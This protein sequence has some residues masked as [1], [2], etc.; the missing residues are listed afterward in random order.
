[1]VP[2]FT[3]ASAVSLVVA[4]LGP[5]DLSAAAR[6]SDRPP[7]CA[8]LSG[9]SGASTWQLA[10]IPSLVAYCELIARAQARLATDPR[11]ARLAA[12]QAEAWL[13][14]RASPQVV[15][16]RAALSMGDAEG[17][18]VLFERAR[19][20]DPRSLDNPSVQRDVALVLVATN[21]RSEARAVYEV[22]V[23]RI[24]LLADNELRV[25][26]LLDAALVAMADEAARPKPRLGE[27]VAYL[28]EATR[29]PPS[30]RASDVLL[31]L[32]LALD[33]AGDPAA[34]DA[35][36]AQLDRLV[37]PRRAEFVVAATIEDRVALSALAEER[38]SGP[39][40]VR[41]WQEVLV[42]PGKASAWAAATRARVERL[43]RSSAP[44]APPK[45]PR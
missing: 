13:P 28:R 24:A 16:G 11:G 37:V 45:R 34:S 44:A 36:L 6:A 21:R 30:A 9:S 10:R 40:A 20:I 19:A 8:P 35:T 4:A 15:L 32:A 18:E 29:L 2:A 17:A 42:G 25:A 23:P 27:V 31:T 5:T 26:V 43:R 22:L 12:E 3:L 39:G 1:V 38:T 33:R 41:L 14:G 7:E